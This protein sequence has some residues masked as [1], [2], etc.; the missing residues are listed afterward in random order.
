MRPTRC[1]VSL[2]WPSNVVIFKSLTR[3]EGISLSFFTFV[4]GAD[5]TNGGKLPSSVPERS[6]NH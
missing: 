1:F 3:F 4:V 2:N 6:Q 5:P